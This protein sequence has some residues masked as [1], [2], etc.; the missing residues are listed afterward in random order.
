VRT[1]YSEDRDTL[2]ENFTAELTRAAYSVALQHRSRSLWIE[3]ELG[4][5]AVIE[6]NSWDATEVSDDTTLEFLSG[7][8]ADWV[9]QNLQL[10]LVS[11]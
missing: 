11:R 1:F 5:Y 8:V 10:V 3:V 2:L 4:L 6:T 7:E 9:I